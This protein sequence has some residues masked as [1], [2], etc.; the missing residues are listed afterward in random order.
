MSNIEDDKEYRLAFDLKLKRPGCVLVAAALGG[1][2]TIL[3]RF[4]TS[5]LLLSPTKDMRVYRIKGYQLKQ[6][7]RNVNLETY[8][9]T[10]RD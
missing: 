4:D 10:V 8:A 7:I 9:K 3:R 6:V 1:N 5:S 2:T